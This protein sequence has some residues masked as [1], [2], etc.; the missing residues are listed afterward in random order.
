MSIHPSTR[1]MIKL[2][3]HPSQFDVNPEPFRWGAADPHQRGPIV[4]TVS[5][6]GKRNA[7]GAHGGT[8]SVY[9]AVA[10]AAHA[11]PVGFRPDFTN[12]LPPCQIGPHPAWSRP[13]AIVSLD[14]WGH[15]PQEI[16]KERMARGELDLRPT[17][18]VTK[19]HL[20]LPEIKDAI[21]AGRLK[22]DGVH[23]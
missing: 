17:I 3:T 19:S 2:T 13:E 20:D 8:Y 22:P 6:P 21:Q 15:L 12:T 10:L 18:S 11:T 9:R 7:V 14:P 16:F 4:A 23:L 5:S 1:H